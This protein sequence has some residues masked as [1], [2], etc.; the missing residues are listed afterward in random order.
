MLFLNYTLHIV[1]GVNKCMLFSLLIYGAEASLR[2]RS[3]VY[4][5]WRY[6]HYLQGGKGLCVI[7]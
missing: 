5:D 2:I 1:N 3:A 6:H 4:E 7:L